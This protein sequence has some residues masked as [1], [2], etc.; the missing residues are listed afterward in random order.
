MSMSC[1]T[2]SVSRK[3]NI[4]NHKGTTNTPRNQQLYNLTGK[5]LQGNQVKSAFETTSDWAS[6][7]G[8]P[9]TLMCVDVSTRL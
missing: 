4:I 8:I 2:A 9:R 3:Y 5:A 7:D 6:S 1:Q